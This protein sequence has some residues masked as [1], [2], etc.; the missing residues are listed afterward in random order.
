MSNAYPD[1][2]R[3]HNDSPVAFKDQYASMPYQ[4]PPGESIIIPFDALCLWFGDPRLQDRPAL[5]Q[6]DRRDEYE[7]IKTRL[8]IQVKEATGE[9]WAW[10]DVWFESLEGERV[11][12]L[13][14]DPEG[15]KQSFANVSRGNLTDA[16]A[17]AQELEI[18]KKQQALL[19]EQ[20]QKLQEQGLNPAPTLA[21]VP[22]DVPTK[23]PV[24]VEK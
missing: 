19:L 6:F 15:S 3:L 11:V 13:I 10:P 8:G 9:Q 22:D 14:E 12:T 21:D 5:V 4:C 24:T 1:I 7:R 17:V 20:L 16:E 23:V 18:V 2:L